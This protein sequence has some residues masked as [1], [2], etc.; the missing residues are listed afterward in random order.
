MCKA[1]MLLGLQ[2]FTSRT[3]Y[4]ERITT[5]SIINMSI[6]YIRTH[7]IVVN[8]FPLTLKM[9][10]FGPQACIGRKCQ[11]GAGVD[12]ATYTTLK[13]IAFWG[14]DKTWVF[15][16]LLLK[17]NIFDS[18]GIG[19]AQRSIWEFFSVGKSNGTL[20]WPPT[21]VSSRNYKRMELLLH[22]LNVFS[23]LKS[24]KI[25]TFFFS[26]F[27]QIFILFTYPFD[28]DF[29]F[30]SCILFTFCLPFILSRLTSSFF[31]FFPCVS[32]VPYLQFIN[33][34]NLCTGMRKTINSLVYP[35]C[36]C[37]VKF[38]HYLCQTN[39]RPYTHLHLVKFLKVER[40]RK[41]MMQLSTVKRFEQHNISNWLKLRCCGL[42]APC[43]AFLQDTNI[44]DHTIPQLYFLDA[45]T[46]TDGSRS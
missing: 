2:V 22:S 26:S 46:M 18:L 4:K 21:P 16:F 39:A 38:H 43:E 12:A 14:K 15:K 30:L 24:R 27:L 29:V 9:V 10:S 23:Q 28:D 19:F 31:S 20:N 25:S 41:F 44:L 11:T 40:A 5:Q 32:F 13:P 6:K 35:A 36:H 34:L 45:S 33:T 3:L 42:P 1:F 17:G 8:V 7:L 37:F